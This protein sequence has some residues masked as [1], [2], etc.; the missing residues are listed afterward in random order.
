[1]M[2]P[3]QLLIAA[4]FGRQYGPDHNILQKSHGE[5]PC[6]VFS[7]GYI[8]CSAVHVLNYPQQGDIFLKLRENEITVDNIVSA[9]SVGNVY[10]IDTVDLTFSCVAA[11]HGVG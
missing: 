9:I 6:K 7:P 10:T 11:T 8:P 5:P 2:P 3:H 1:M 4:F